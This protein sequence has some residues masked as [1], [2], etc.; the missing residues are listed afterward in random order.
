MV[1]NLEYMEKCLENHG[2]YYKEE[3]EKIKKTIRDADIIEEFGD[4]I[5]TEL[6]K[7]AA[8]YNG[9]YGHAFDRN[10]DYKAPGLALFFLYGVLVGSQNKEKE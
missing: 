1:D 7:F 9:R 5:G 8:L 3:A 2:D 6:E 4:N 10:M